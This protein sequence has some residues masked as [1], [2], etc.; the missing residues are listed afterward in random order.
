[1]L[2][3]N[4]LRYQRKLKQS[5][6]TA[7]FGHLPDGGLISE[8]K[9]RIH[10]RC[11]CCALA[12]IVPNWQHFSNKLTLSHLQ[13]KMSLSSFLRSQKRLQQ[14]FKL[15]DFSGQHVPIEA[16]EKQH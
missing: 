3:L 8:T 1:M 2:F 7:S 6:V 16:P 4:R 5:L 9:P 15:L 10:V 12:K 11:Y 13:V 14:P